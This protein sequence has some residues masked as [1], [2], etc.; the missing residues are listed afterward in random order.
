MYK[1]YRSGGFLR[2]ERYDLRKVTMLDLIRLAYGFEPDAV[3]GGP[4]W[5]ALTRFD[6][7]ARTRASTS[8]QDLR[9][10]LQALLAE[11]FALVLHKDVR[12][13]PAFA[14]KLARDKPKIKKHEGPGDAECKYLRQPGGPLSTV[15]ACRNVTM[16]GFAQQLRGMAGDYL[17][18]PVV[19][20]TGLAGEWD[21]TILRVEQPYPNTGCRH[22]THHDIQRDRSTVGSEA[23]A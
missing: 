3:P 10:M 16:A 11:R 5:L 17:T 2:G 19:D 20:E 18:D 21:F 9:L 1:S 15:Y 23:D 6:I 22:G 8:P 14:L 13:V 7:A 12:P 4:D